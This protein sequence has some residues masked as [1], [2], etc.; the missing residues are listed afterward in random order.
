MGSNGIM[1]GVPGPP[2]LRLRVWESCG[3]VHA[4][5]DRARLCWLCSLLD[6]TNK[7]IVNK[8]VSEFILD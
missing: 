8:G 1:L 7:K 2:P 6:E 5:Q 4:E 3:V